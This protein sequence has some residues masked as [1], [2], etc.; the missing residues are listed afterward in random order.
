MFCPSCG[1][2]IEDNMAFCPVCG[3]NI[4][5]TN[6][7]EKT[8]DNNNEPDSNQ[9]QNNAYTPNGGYNQN[10]GYNRNGGYNQNNGYNT[11]GGYNQNNGYNTSGGYNQNNGYNPNGGYN[12]NGGYNPNGGYGTPFQRTVTPQMKQ[13]M[14]KQLSEKENIAFIIALILGI[15]QC[16]SFAGIIAGVWN[17]IVAVQRQ[18][19]SKNILNMPSGLMR[20]YENSLTNIIIGGVINFL[21]GGVIGVALAVYDYFTRDFVLK[22]PDVFQ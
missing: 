1:N 13:Q 6:Q 5:T 10:N 14:F 15:I 12:Q 11:N 19:L 21:F 4:A 20:V 16:L 8:L 18:K 3:K 22:N 9:N 7:A 2:S 17:I